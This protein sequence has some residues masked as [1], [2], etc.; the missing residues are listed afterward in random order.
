ML[1]GKPG[2]KE[3][4]SLV[5]FVETKCEDVF[6]NKMNQLATKVELADTKSELIKWM[7]I[8]WAGQVVVISGILI[9]VLNAYLK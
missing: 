3:A 8:F 7:F 2:D 4:G 1:K 6:F 5:Q 9:G